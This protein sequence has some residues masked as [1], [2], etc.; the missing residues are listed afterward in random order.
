[1]HQPFKKLQEILGTGPAKSRKKSER[2][3]LARDNASLQ[4]PAPAEEQPDAASESDEEQL[5][6]EQAMQG[7]RPLKG[8][9]R[10][11]AARP[12]KRPEDLRQRVEDPALELNRVVNGE[13]EFLLEY[14]GEYMEGRVQG[15]DRKTMDK[16][17]AGFFSVETHLDMH[18]MNSDQARIAL[19][20]F[21]RSSY[22]SGY[23]C[24]LVVT[25]RGRNSP[26]G[27]SVLRQEL[28][29]WLTR[30]P[31]KRIVLAFVTAQPRHGGAGAIYVLL[32]SLKKKHGK[33]V[34]ED[35]FVHLDG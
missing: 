1:M 34:W 31:L 6:F 17:R 19:L 24:V 22:V 16:L 30:H 7:I 23:K 12:K 32:R 11:V 8:R 10:Q 2:E 4:A 20:D 14:T 18:G 9:G 26:M 33:I 3:K 27:Q 13:C 5:L 25:G 15:L 29:G 35:V 28:Q 21:I